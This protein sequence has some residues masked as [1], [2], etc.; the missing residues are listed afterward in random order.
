MHLS[1]TAPRWAGP[2]NLRTLEQDERSRVRSKSFGEIAD[3][4][5]RFRPGPPDEAVTWLIPPGAVDVLEIGAGTGGLTRQLVSRVDHVRAVEPDDRM[6]AVLAERVTQAE[7]VAGQAEEIPADDASF[8][9]VI[10]SS[11]WHWVDE[12]RAVPEVAR[13]LRPGGRLSLLWGG[14]DRSVEWVGSLF[15]GGTVLSQEDR[16]DREARRRERYAVHLGEA[17][18]FSEP[19]RRLI[20]WTKSMTREEALGF[21]GTF[22]IAI[23]MSPAQRA[24]YVEG[25]SRFLDT[26]EDWSGDGTIDMPMRCLCWRASLR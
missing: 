4:Y 25:V 10:L 14:P 17:N 13:V 24:E 23:T 16:A 5:D 1:A 11:A 26:W 20:E 22:S 15:S 21:V 2:G 19:E 9:M 7:V 18:P 8:D 3:E 6:R 12:K